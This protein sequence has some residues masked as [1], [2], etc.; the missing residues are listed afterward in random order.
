VRVLPSLSI[1]YVLYVPGSPFN[2]ISL[3]QLI[4]SHECVVTF[5]KGNVTLQDRISGR[6]IGVGCES[7]G[8]YYLLNP[9]TACPT[10]DSPLTIHAQLGH[11]SLLKLQKVGP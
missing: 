5:T 10:I 3:S 4:R 9:S 11:P 7:N 6:Q 2:L 1:T 8:L